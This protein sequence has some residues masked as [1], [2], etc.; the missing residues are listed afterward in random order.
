MRPLAAASVWVATT[1]FPANI[2]LT[3]TSICCCAASTLF[4]WIT[5]IGLA[6]PPANEFEQRTLCEGFAALRPARTIGCVPGVEVDMR[7]RNVGGDKVLQEQGGGDR[8]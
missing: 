2:R 8:A 3:A 4:T 7:P 5:A 6:E 1:S